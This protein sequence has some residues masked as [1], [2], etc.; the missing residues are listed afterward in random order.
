MYTTEDFAVRIG[1]FPD[2]VKP[3]CISDFFISNHNRSDALVA[4]LCSGDQSRPSI[5][6]DVRYVENPEIR[7]FKNIRGMFS[8]DYLKSYGL[9]KSK[10]WEFQAEVRYAIQ[11]IPM[12]LRN[13]KFQ[14]RHFI[15]FEEWIF[16]DLGTNI[17]FIDVDYQFAHMERAD[18]T[19]GPSTT[20]THMDQIIAY[21]ESN[22]P[23]YRG[24]IS[25]C[26]ARI[27]SRS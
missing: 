2:F 21:L 13:T 22:M 17:D 11:A 19:L 10:E 27:R 26:E 6:N 12:P 16:N 25:R 5:L 18:I 3:T 14:E 15:F 7:M 1:L 23:N 20:N 8:D 4:P 24:N 9:L